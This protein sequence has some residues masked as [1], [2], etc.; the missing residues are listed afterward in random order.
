MQRRMIGTTQTHNHLN[1]AQPACQDQFLFKLFKLP[2]KQT[3]SA[4]VIHTEEYDVEGALARSGVR[5][6]TNSSPYCGFTLAVV[7]PARWPE[8]E[9]SPVS[10]FASPASHIRIPYRNPR[11]LHR[12]RCDR[13]CSRPVVVE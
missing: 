1:S 13:N 2:S 10:A 6:Y 8:S 11:K 3:A 9:S 7:F 12:S 4:T 5:D